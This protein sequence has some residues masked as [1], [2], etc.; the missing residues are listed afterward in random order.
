MSQSLQSLPDRPDASTTD[1][2]VLGLEQSLEAL[3]E[4]SE[5]GGPVETLGSYESNDHLAAIYEGQ[6]EQFATAVPFMRTGLERGDRCL[7]IADENEID[8]VLSAMDDAGVDVDRAL[9][10]GAL[11]M[12]TAQDTYFRNGEFTPE[13]MIA[14]ISDAIDDAREEYE[15]LR[16][17][18][19]MTW[20][21]GDDPELETL[22]EYEAKLNDLL[23]DSNGIA[24]CQ[25][26][27]NRFPAE[28]IRDVIKTHPHLVYENTVCQNFYYTPPEE[29][30]GPEQ[31]EQEVDRMMG[32][33]LDRTRARTEL[34]D[35]Q[36]HLQR[37]NEITADPNRPFDEKLEGLFDL[38]CQQFDLELGGMARVD[39]DDDRIEIE[40]VS[41]DHD[42]LEQGREL[43]LSETYCD[44]VF[45]EDQT[46]GLS[47]A[48]EGD[49]EYAD[50]EIHE[51]GGLRSYLGTRI[52]VDGD[53]DRT[54]F[55]VDPEG[56][57][58]PFTADERTFLRLMGQW[59]EYELE[60]QQREEE[61]EQSIDR[62][63]KS[64]ERLEQ[65]AYAAS[66]DLQ[67]PLRMV[68]SYLRLLESR[69]EDDL[70]DDGREFLEFAVDGA[71]R[72]REMIEG[73]LA[74]SRVETAGEPL[75]PVDLDDVLDDVL[76]DL[77]LRIEE[78]DATITR[79]PLPIIDGD[80][81]QLRQVCQNLLANAI[82]YSG[83]EPP[84][85][86]V[87]AERSESDEA[88]AEDEWI[89]SV[90]DEGIGI[91]PAETDRIFD[92]FDRLHSREEY[93]GAGIGLALCERIVERHDGR[94]WADS[95][96]GEGSTFSI[97][98]PCAGDSSPQ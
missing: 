26:N 19:E 95:E 73:L 35:R 81:N 10:S 56:R 58:E 69:Y 70:D 17:T 2:D 45:D 52:E 27:R 50:T 93:D 76:D 66:H 49:E 43:P 59:V 94:I 42:Y 41:D 71:D 80:G 97:A 47:L 14:F 64:N 86:H 46:V 67:E 98:F 28:V 72:M 36:E 4:S 7:Y 13:D 9:E 53:R 74:Y 82:E 79:D 15:G 5:F 25:Y 87:S 3:Q 22:I 34:T 55:F 8:E 84:R 77:Q 6:D 51:D 30:F 1:D 92:V 44:A 18:G 29:F 54:F 83:D 96:P 78:S 91:D 12:H 39:P 57:E 85:I 88:T 32:T 65:F 24:L 90:H 20:I 37:Q 68:S 60:R 61:L 62:L 48:L 31:P 75:E 16:I 89:V 23:P 38:G 33:L 21:L 11:T 63:E 40:R